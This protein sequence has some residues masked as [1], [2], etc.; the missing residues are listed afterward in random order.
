[1]IDASRG[2]V[3]DCGDAISLVVGAM[4]PFGDDKDLCVTTL[5]HVAGAACGFHDRPSEAISNFLTIF[6]AAVNLAVP[7]CIVTDKPGDA[8]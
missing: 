6:I 8:G 3:I 2:K 4:R 1:M 7:G 5:A